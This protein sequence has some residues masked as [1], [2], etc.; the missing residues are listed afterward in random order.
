M[1]FYNKPCIFIVSTGRTATAFFGETMSQM[2]EG[3]TSRHEADVLGLGRPHEWI[4]KV[5]EFGLFHMTA[6]K[7]LPR[8]SLRTLGVARRSGRL[9]DAKI[10]EY[11]RQLRK[12]I[13]TRVSS[14]VYLEA[15]NQYSA[16]LDLLPVAFPNSRLVYIIRD[17]RS[18]VS[19][20]LSMRFPFYSWRDVRSWFK[21]GRL[22]PRHIPGDPALAQWR[23]MTPFEKLCWAW[24]RENAYAL[25]CARKTAAAQIVRYEDLFD[26]KTS[27]RTFIQILEFI[28]NF[29]GGEKPRWTL[30]PELLL[31]RFNLAKG[32]PFPHWT[33][34]SAADARRLDR[35]CRSLM[36][37]FQYGQEPDW[38]EKIGRI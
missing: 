16:F 38:R 15:N 2:I 30:K 29:P 7:L 14:D 24:A 33:E 9:P 18:W 17:P 37:Q 3:C 31:R 10:V 36:D 4:A 25:E 11:L 28:T 21:N 22:N 20:W 27:H 6:G 1:R 5:R 8:Y 12:D 32:K 35:Y 13:L 34:W 23:C 19:S 26:E